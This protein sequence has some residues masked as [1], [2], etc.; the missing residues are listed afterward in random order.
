MRYRLHKLLH[1]PVGSR[2]SASLD[3]G[4]FAFDET[5]HVPFLRGE[6]LFTRL[7][8]AILVQGQIET[9]VTLQCVRSLERFDLPLKVALEGVL[10]SLPNFPAEEPS[11]QVS[12]DGWI[13]LTETLREEIILSMPTNPIHPKFV[14]ADP[15][16]LLSELEVEEAADWL[17]IKLANRDSTEER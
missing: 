8:R 11:R 1:E 15:R 6:F 17:S 7:S 4:A 3:Q 5:L 14:H 9:Q 13:D 10:F 2:Q 12:D 16:D